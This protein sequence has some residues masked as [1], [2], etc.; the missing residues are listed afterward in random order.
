MYAICQ[1]KKHFKLYY[2]VLKDNILYVSKSQNT[3]NRLLVCGTTDF[4]F[5]RYWYIWCYNEIH[6]PNEKGQPIK[7][8]L[9]CCVYSG[10][11]TH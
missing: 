5:Q 3:R 11:L 1:K 8:T 2:Y 4:C 6:G 10:E 7:T 9:T